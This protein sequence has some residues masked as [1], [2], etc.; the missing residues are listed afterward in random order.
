MILPV[1]SIDGTV[2]G[3]GAPGPV[4]RRIQS[5]YYAHCGFDIAARAPWLDR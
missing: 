2:V 1:V 3:S 4:T 5:T